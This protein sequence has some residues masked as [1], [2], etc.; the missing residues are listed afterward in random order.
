[1]LSSLQA[2][3]FGSL[4]LTEIHVGDFSRAS[5]KLFLDILYLQKLDWPSI[6]FSS[7]SDL[8][9]LA[10]KY[11][12]AGLETFLR[13]KLVTKLRKESGLESLLEMVNQRTG[14]GT[15]GWKISEDLLKKQAWPG[16]EVTF[17]QWRSS[18]EFWAL[19]DGSRGQWHVI[20]V[21]RL[22]KK[23]LKKLFPY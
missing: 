11:L 22:L 13:S 19:T 23:L 10:D 5:F 16:S 2:Q 1:M 18:F 7:F 9:R 8:C 21:C 4:K 20:E 3:F 14:Q 15:L 12:V 17:A 6:K